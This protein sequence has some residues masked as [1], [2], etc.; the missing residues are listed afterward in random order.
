MLVLIGLGIA[1]EKDLSLR[2]LEEA[3]LADLLYAEFYTSPWM[4]SKKKLEDLIGKHV[5]ELSRVD[6]EERANKLIE[7]A[8]KKRVALLVPGDPLIATTHQ[9]LLVEARK[10][11]I[12]VRVIHASSVISA[13]AVTGLHIYKFGKM[14]TIPLCEKTKSGLPASVYETIKTNHKLG[15]HTLCLLD[16]SEERTMSVVEALRTLLALEEKYGKGILTKEKKIL[17]VSRLGSAP[18]I[19][20]GRLADLLKKNFNLPASLV[21]PGKL[22]FT[23]EEALTSF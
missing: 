3:R 7:Q 11:G 8:K 13:I 16:L 9:A 12:D 20:Y 18:L 6:L 23:E 15:L 19:A 4:G 17:V 22:H 5:I 10:L 14:V 1:D 2:G 21:I